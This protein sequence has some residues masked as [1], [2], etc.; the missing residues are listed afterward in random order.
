MYWFIILNE[1]LSE[2]YVLYEN[3]YSVD[4]YC[5]VIAIENFTW[6]WSINCMS[7]LELQFDVCRHRQLISVPATNK[8]ANPGREEGEVNPKAITYCQPP[9]YNIR[10][11]HQSASTTAACLKGTRTPPQPHDGL[12]SPTPREPWTAGGKRTRD[13]DDVVVVVGERNEV[14]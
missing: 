10:N 2:Y 4:W 12:T 6:S 7:G 13:N 5:Q 1:C 11:S 9:N 8:T 3:S 14:E